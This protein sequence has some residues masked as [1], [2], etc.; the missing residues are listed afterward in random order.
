MS[1]IWNLLTWLPFAVGLLLLSG[2]DGGGNFEM[3]RFTSVTLPGGGKGDMFTFLSKGAGRQ[4]DIE[5][6]VDGNKKRTLESLFTSDEDWVIILLP[7]KTQEVRVFK[8]P[9]EK[10][11]RLAPIDIQVDSL[12]GMIPGDVTPAATAGKSNMFFNKELGFRRVG[13]DTEETVSHEFYLIEK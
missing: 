7:E 12:S 10:V 5:H 3:G 11:Y 8:W 2:C 9:D 4:I 6:Y 13:S 1:K